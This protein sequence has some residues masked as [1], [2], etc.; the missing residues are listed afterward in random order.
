MFHVPSQKT[1]DNTIVYLDNTDANRFILFQRY[2]IPINL[3]I[4]RK[5]FDQKASTITLH[6]NNLGE[7][8]NITRSDLLYLKGVGFENTNE[9]ACV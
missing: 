7:I 4:E 3:C 5:V 1:M 8:V 2:F 6:F 9:T